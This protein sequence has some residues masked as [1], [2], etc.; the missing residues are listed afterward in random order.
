MIGDWAFLGILFFL[1]LTGFLLE[2]F[3][4]AVTD[5]PFEVWSPA[6]WALGPA[7]IS[8]GLEGDAAESARLAT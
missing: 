5:P 8:L 1:A 7:F 6:G 4:I 2:G 3:R